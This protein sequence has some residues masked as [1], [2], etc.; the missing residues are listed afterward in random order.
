VNDAVPTS[1]NRAARTGTPR[2]VPQGAILIG[3]QLEADEWAA[4]VARDER[5]RH[6]A[7][8]LARQY[9]L[10]I[11]TPGQTT[12]S[13]I[14][15]VLRMI[16]GRSDAWAIARAAARSMQ[17]D[18]FVYATDETIGIPYILAGSK[19]R[20]RSRSTAMFVLAPHRT[21]TRV[22]LSVLDRLRLLPATLV[23]GTPEVA[24]H[25][26]Q[27]FVTSSTAVEVVLLPVAIDDQFFR[28]PAAPPT[29]DRPLVVSA[30]LEHRDYE[31]L[32]A[33]TRNLDID[34]DVC[35]VSPDRAG[36]TLLPDTL[37]S[38]MK[39]APLS[40]SGLRDLYQRAD[41]FVL[42]T[43]PNTLN[44]GLSAVMEALACGLDVVVSIHE[45]DIANLIAEGHVTAT[46]D[47]SASALAQTIEERLAL[48]SEAPRAS[49]VRL[50]A[51]AYVEQLGRLF[52]RRHAIVSV[53]E[54]DDE[55]PALPGE[56]IDPHLL[57]V[58]IPVAGTDD[59]LRAQLSALLTQDADTNF[60]VIIAHNMPTDEQR[61]WLTRTLA[62][63][64]NQ[65]LW[66]VEANVRPSAAHARNAGAAAARGALL[67][68]C[69]A[70]DVVHPGWVDA[71]AASLERH[72]A[73][74]GRIVEVAPT[75]QSDWRPPATPGALPTFHGAPYMLSGNLGIRRSAFES[76]GGFDESLTRCEDIALGWALQNRG[77]DIA[78]A[79]DAVLDYHHRAGLRK[80]LVQHYLYGRGMAEVLAKY[81]NPL[82][83]D[84]SASP[85]AKRLA[86]LR[87]NSQPHRRT[88]VSTMRRIA[89]GVGRI[90]GLVAPR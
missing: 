54:H 90:V 76:V 60:E 79:P 41:L 30:G 20:Q 64:D 70:D 23:A 12:S 52:E 74:T 53:A 27:R 1:T 21:R 62:P 42:S 88:V 19:R 10:E 83:S 69:D 25:L 40:L 75:G 48:R 34:V 72:D 81:P 36:A 55:A 24:A 17:P 28:P 6:Y 85:A 49:W 68:F 46:P 63:F 66:V 61:D 31:R 3:R 15:S 86:R 89:I 65:S 37:P 80:M 18:Q 71:M 38:N 26:E 82:H 14:D 47:T 45:P 58:I 11:I 39:L 87:P 32:A 78:Y 5:P 35:A 84:G 29:N 33:A 8:D 44:A 22:W 77:H 57:S 56:T 50:T 67:A 73:V 59:A 51:D 4:A 7:F 43:A 2:S 9:A 13:R 16:I